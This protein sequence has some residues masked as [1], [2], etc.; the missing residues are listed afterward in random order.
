MKTATQRFIEKAIE[1]GWNPESVE[2]RTDNHSACFKAILL[3]I[4]A[5]KAV[6]EVEA[7]KGRGFNLEAMAYQGVPMTQEYDWNWLEN[8]H[9]MIDAIAD[10]RSIEEYLDEIV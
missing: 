5:W 9:R 6:G 4:E 10:G 1:G 7:K 2:C 8:M 3:D